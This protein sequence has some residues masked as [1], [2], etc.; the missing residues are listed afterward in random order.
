VGQW[1]ADLRSGHIDLN[2]HKG[3]KLD[4]TGTAKNGSRDTQYRNYEVLKDRSKTVTLRLT[5]PSGTY[6]PSE[7]KVEFLSDDQMRID[8]ITSGAESV[9][10]NRK[11]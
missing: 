8:F 9:V 3:G 5:D 4:F 7:W 2:I 6:D 10:Y 1:G 11:K